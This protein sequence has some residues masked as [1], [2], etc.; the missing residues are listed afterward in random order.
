MYIIE[1]DTTFCQ[2][3]VCSFPISSLLFP[4]HCYTR[5]IVMNE[6][7]IPKKKPDATCSNECCLR[8]IL[9]LPTMPETVSVRQ[10]HHIGLKLNNNEK[11]SRE[12]VTPPIAAVWVDI[13]H[14]TL[15]IAQRICITNAT[16][17]IDVSMCGRC[18]TFII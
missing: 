15:M 6:Q 17:S 18:S 3:V 10:S 16:I 7:T 11:A 2:S 14:H 13:F 9:L 12:P 5:I 4:S 8:I 1:T